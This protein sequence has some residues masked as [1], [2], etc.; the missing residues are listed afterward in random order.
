MVCLQGV[1]LQGFAYRGVCLWGV[2]QTPLLPVNRMTH[3]CKNITLPETSFAGGNYEALADL[4]RR[5]QHTLF[6]P[7]LFV[8]FMQ[9]L[10][11]FDQI[12][13]SLRIWGILD[14]SPAT[15]KVALVR[16]M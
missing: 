12:M 6:Y 8:T 14:P 11:K 2:G 1:S 16:V 3:R 5:R 10:G 4:G 13:G 15:V 7:S 9:F